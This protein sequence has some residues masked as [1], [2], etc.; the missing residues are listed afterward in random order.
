MLGNL[1][2]NI[3]FG[4]FGSMRFE[5]GDALTFIPNIPIIIPLLIAKIDGLKEQLLIII[6]MKKNSNCLQNPSIAICCHLLCSTK[7][8]D[9][10]DPSKTGNYFF[11]I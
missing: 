3:E 4:T 8:L 11:G 9:E 6:F 7:S 1:E 10:I 2:I 5:C